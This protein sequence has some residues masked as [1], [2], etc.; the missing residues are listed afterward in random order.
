MTDPSQGVSPFRDRS[1][2]VATAIVLHVIR[3]RIYFHEAH[4]LV[5]ACG[6][7]IFPYV[8]SCFVDA[9]SSCLHKYTGTLREH[10]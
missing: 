9:R 3:S 10:P 1:S 2:T 5:S 8:L 7:H 6:P 4:H